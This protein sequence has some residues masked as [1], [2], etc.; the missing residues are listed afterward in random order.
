MDVIDQYF[1]DHI[2]HS[3]AQSDGDL[4]GKKVKNQDRSQSGKDPKRQSF[5]QTS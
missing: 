4:A 5:N 2:Y 3:G 1:D